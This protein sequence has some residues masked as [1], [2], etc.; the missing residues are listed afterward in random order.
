M[1]FSAYGDGYA[2]SACDSL[3]A[4]AYRRGFDDFVNLCEPCARGLSA[5]IGRVF[6][7]RRAER[8]RA[9]AERRGKARTLRLSPASLEAL[10]LL[11]AAPHGFARIANE[12]SHATDGGDPVVNATIAHWL[13]GRGYAFCAGPEADRIYPTDAG[14]E[15]LKQPTF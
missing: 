5:C 2:C 12:A 9:A 3:E 6:S 11:A 13:V 10:R 15:E 1:S 14:K 7:A 4:K 8:R